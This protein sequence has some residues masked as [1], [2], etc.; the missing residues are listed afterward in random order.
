MSAHA[1][2]RASFQGFH[3]ARTESAGW[4]R[5]HR[6]SRCSGAAGETDLLVGFRIEQEGQSAT[7]Q[8]G[9]ATIT[10]QE[11][12]DGRRR[13]SESVAAQGP[14]I[15][16]ETS[17]SCSHDKETHPYAVTNAGKL[18]ILGQILL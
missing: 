6:R 16:Q 14:F 5:T 18:K 9:T 8:P 1:L 4:P 10:H 11:P 13:R 2:H 12:A 15:I 17:S 7:S 3:P